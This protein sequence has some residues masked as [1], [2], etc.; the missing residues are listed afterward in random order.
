MKQLK[1]LDT[2]ENFF[3][4]FVPLV[5]EGEG[6]TVQKDQDQLDANFTQQL[7][8]YSTSLKLIYQ[9]ESRKAMYKE[10][11]AAQKQC[12]DYLDSLI[13][14][15]ADDF[16]EQFQKHRDSVFTTGIK[17]LM[18]INKKGFINFFNLKYLSL[19]IEHSIQH[20]YWAYQVIKMH[21]KESLKAKISS[22]ITQIAF[23]NEITIG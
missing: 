1:D 12:S 17:V 13:Q 9:D 11:K 20:N 16:E 18:L 22:D 15:G 8:N 4:D 14:F 7:N 21:I 10:K 6:K 19:P 2:L 3:F 23:Q 5:E